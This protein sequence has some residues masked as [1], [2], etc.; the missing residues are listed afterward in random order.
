MIRLLARIYTQTNYQASYRSLS[1]SSINRAIY[2]V[3]VATEKQ[4]R[5]FMCTLE[6]ARTINHA[7]VSHAFFNAIE[8]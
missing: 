1:V 6:I 2:C 7:S 8:A 4:T 3:C 5:L